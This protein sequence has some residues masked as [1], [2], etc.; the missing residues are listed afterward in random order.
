MHKKSSKSRGQSKSLWSAR[1][2]QRSNALDL[3]PKVFRS[4][5]PR[6]I[7]LSPKRSA[8]RR[9][10]RKAGPYQSA[11]SMLNFYINRAGKIFRKIKSAFLKTPKKNCAA[12]LAEPRALLPGVEI[13]VRASGTFSRYKDLSPAFQAEN[14]GHRCIRCPAQTGWSPTPFS[15]AP[16]LRNAN[17]PSSPSFDS[18]ALQSG[19]WPRLVACECRGRTSHHSIPHAIQSRGSFCEHDDA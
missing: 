6:K 8:Q 15:Q 11:M 13:Q 14:C 17:R 18:P 5:N 9:K 16:E 1:V 12:Y 7:A 3:E 4:T 2:T 10:R 19:R